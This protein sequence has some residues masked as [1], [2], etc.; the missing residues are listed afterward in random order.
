M[1]VIPT[2]AADGVGVVAAGQLNAYLVSAPNTAT[3]R[4][5][6]GQTGMTAYLQGINVPN[7]GGQGAFY[8]NY[9]SVAPDDNFN[10]IVPYGSVYG[11]WA[12]LTN[13]VAFPTGTAGYAYT[14]NGTS[15][16]ATFQG[17]TQ[18]GTGA[19]TRTWQAK[20]ADFI[21]VKDFGAIGDGVTDDTSAIQKAINYAATYTPGGAVFLPS[22]TYKISAALGVPPGASMT[23][24]GSGPGAT[25]IK[26][27]S[28]TAN[29]ITFFNS[30]SVSLLGGGVYNLT[31]YCASYSSGIG[32]YLQKLND[33][34]NFSNL[35]VYNFSTG[36]SLDE[37][38]NTIWSNFTVRAASSAAIAIGINNSLNPGG[39]NSFVNFFL[40]NGGT[41]A[42]GNGS[43][44]LIKKTGGDFFTNGNITSFSNGV[45]LVC[46]GVTN[47]DST[48]P[49]IN[50]ANFVQT[51]FDT[52]S[53]AGVL[54]DGT[55]G[56]GIAN[57]CFA[58]C[59]AA[60][61]G[62]V[63]IAATGNINSFVWSEGQLTENV[64]QGASFT[65]TGSYT[66]TNISFPGGTVIAGNGRNGAVG[67]S[68]AGIITSGA[69]Q[70]TVLNNAFGNAGTAYATQT[71]AM[72]FGTGLTWVKM[73]NNTIHT[74]S[75]AA[76]YINSSS[77]TI[78]TADSSS[79]LVY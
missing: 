32:L 5:L 7:D 59:A 45:A 2:I 52:C 18:N 37:C 6:T 60:Y 24:Y 35:V 75:G 27:T 36:I 55:L 68:A 22:G 56:Y 49:Q 70:L 74:N 53:Y 66:Q 67:I 77:Y 8:W 12:R 47:P 17:F 15:S 10:T 72:V 50:H 51:W 39:G 40:D 76:A 62:N 63:G 79:N 25:S 57:V 44:I 64:Y 58:R 28:T 65:A 30:S 46:S 33:Y 71:N 26:Q 4:A 78:P 38:F 41:G 21:S 54:I 69:V 23:I 61:S 42:S 11:A 13:V 14:G 29:G 43:G 9:A 20:A 31:I 3:L 19:V 1:S 34:F 48:I 16:A 73:G